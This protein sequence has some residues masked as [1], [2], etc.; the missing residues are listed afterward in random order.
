VRQR[1]KTLAFCTTYVGVDTPRKGRWNTRYR[2]WVDAM[3]SNGVEFDQLLM[4]DDGSPDP[5]N[6]PD[7][8]VGKG[9][10]DTIPDAPLLLYHFDDRLGRPSVSDF[11]GWV[12]SFFFAAEFALR[13][14]FDRVIHIE[15]DAFLIGAEVTRW[16]NSTSTG[17][18]AL[19]CQHYARPETGIQLIAGETIHRW[20]SFAQQP[21]EALRG[22]VIE[23]VLPFTAVEHR[24]E[25][26]RYTEYLDHVPR[27]AEWCMQ[28]ECPIQSD[29]SSFYWW[30]PAHAIETISDVSSGTEQSTARSRRDA[31]PLNSPLANPV[32]MPVHDLSFE[33]MLDLSEFAVGDTPQR[34]D[35]F[36]G[37]LSMPPGLVRIL[38][39]DGTIREGELQYRAALPPV[40]LYS[41]PGHVLGA[42]GAARGHG[43]S[44]SIFWREDCSAGFVQKAL[45]PS[46]GDPESALDEL[47]PSDWAGSLNDPNADVIDLDHPVAMIVQR[48]ASDGRTMLD[49]LPRVWL[50]AKLAQMGRPL[51]VALDTGAPD[52]LVSLVS[53]FVPV[54][55][56]VRYD[57]RRHLL[58]APAVIMPSRMQFDG[59]LHPTFNLLVEDVL[60][61]VLVGGSR[62]DPARKLFMSGRGSDTGSVVD[63]VDALE[64]QLVTAGYEVLLPH[65]MTFTERLRAMAGASA[66]I[67]ETGHTFADVLFAPRGSTLVS[68]GK[69]DGALERIA[70]LRGQSVGS[71]EPPVGLDRLGDADLPAH[72]RVA[73][74]AG[75]IL[76]LVEACAP[77]ASQAG[78]SPLIAVS[79]ETLHVE[80]YVAILAHGTDN[81]I[82]ALAAEVTVPEFSY[83]EPVDV[84][85]AP[86]SR[87]FQPQALRSYS[88]QAVVC[89]RLGGASLLGDSGLV[90]WQGRVPVDAADRA[91]W[92]RASGIELAVGPKNRPIQV[93][94]DRRSHPGRALY[95]AFTGGWMDDAAF[96]VECLPRLVAY[97]R[98]SDTGTLPTMMMPA[99]PPGSIQQ[100]ALDLL[101]IPGVETIAQKQVATGSAV[102][103]PSAIDLWRPSPLVLEAA[104]A[105]ADRVAP[106]QVPT[107]RRLYL[108]APRDARPPLRG[109][110][111]LVPVLA[112]HGFEAVTLAEYDL[113]TRIHLMRGAEIVVSEAAA[114]S[115]HVMFCRPGAQV[116]ELFNP[117]F[118]QPATYT[119]AALAGL[120]FGFLVGQH[121]PDPGFEQPSLAS[122][123]TV[124]PERLDAALGAVAAN[125]VAPPPA[126]PAPPPAPIFAPSAA[127]PIP[128]TPIP[129]TPIP[130]AP[131]PAVPHPAISAART[132]D[133]SR[134]LTLPRPF[135]AAPSLP[136]QARTSQAVTAVPRSGVSLDGHGVVRQTIASD[137]A[138]PGDV[139]ATLTAAGVDPLLGALPRLIAA[140][141]LRDQFPQARVVLPLSGPVRRLAELL[142]LIDGSVVLSPDAAV[143]AERLWLVEGLEPA[144]DAL[145]PE[146]LRRAGEALRDAVPA[147]DAEGMG[148]IPARLLIC[149]TQPDA[150][151]EIALTAHGFVAVAWTGLSIDEQVRVMRTARLIVLEPGHAACLVLARPGTRVL[152]A[153]YPTARSLA[154]ICGLDYGCVGDASALD[155][156]VEALVG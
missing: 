116:L 31:A 46:A 112:R 98:L 142:G 71:V 111:A 25:G 101:Q 19:W 65:A 80:G 75:T 2:R 4:I 30:L 138:L 72:Q 88:A 103:L 110:E 93:P 147:T 40:S 28:A 18:T 52:W 85:V 33:R 76:R 89:A 106:P 146:L 63:D 17:W 20:R 122:A 53:L 94:F 97:T 41:L 153:G 49:A 84:A 92:D 61:R 145:P 50:I 131:I 77:R 79:R 16:A 42:G 139:V 130:A 8:A 1:S 7:C 120:G 56:V 143:T 156:A 124:T 105:L 68:V 13:R 136:D 26:D 129:A 9:D 132:I 60:S 118:V 81:P 64:H 51:H 87:M 74:D 83:R 21:I 128:A 57:A 38:G 91:Y 99:L 36:S 104:R 135:F 123:Y 69:T 108:R 34:F 35:V 121:V 127:T 96:L 140:R 43:S 117:V 10:L 12:R 151:L 11:P 24:F 67:S 134:Q 86:Y 14:G 95:Q 29:P 137:T 152:E 149:A 37:A 58:R 39:V 155:A 109:Y 45:S 113:D 66:I 15:S 44:L 100:R 154:A 82:L 62:P 73:I 78:S 55:R 119:L 114:G 48:H 22:I 150:M 144:A 107:P 23:D 148:L 70:A 141:I 5:P 133:P 126:A 32:S 59:Y 102:W 125:V 115:A 3:R 90:V 47:P 27:T 54:E 6:W